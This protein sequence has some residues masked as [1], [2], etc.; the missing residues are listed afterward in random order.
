MK[1]KYLVLITILVAISIIIY[2]QRASIQG[3]VVSQEIRTVPLSADETNAVSSVIA[4]SEFVE[5]LPESGVIALRFYSFDEQ[6]RI[7]S[8]AFLIGRDGLLSEGEPDMYI[9]IHSKYIEQFGSLSLCDI[10]RTANTNGDFAF[11]S[12]KSKVSLLVKYSGMVKHK[13][14]LG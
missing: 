5:D 4:T 7:W 1:R 14:C 2:I 12:D 9:A 6:G 8:D 3:N 13:G 11:H 10:I